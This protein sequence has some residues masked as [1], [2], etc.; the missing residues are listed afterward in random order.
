MLAIFHCA[1]EFLGSCLKVDRITIYTD[2][3]AAI[4]ALSNDNT[5]SKIVREC[6]AILNNLYRNKVSIKWMPCHSSGITGNEKAETIPIR[7]KL[8]SAIF[9]ISANFAK[10][11]IGSIYGKKFMKYSKDKRRQHSL[12][13]PDNSCP[14]RSNT[15]L[16]M[17]RSSLKT[18]IAIYTVN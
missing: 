8:I 9:S 5:R 4:R 16:V 11:I 15:I 12:L 18:I 17:S 7:H 6:N 2:S 13:F 14:S 3:Q 1:C 10:R